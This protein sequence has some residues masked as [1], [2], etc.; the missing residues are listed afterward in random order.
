MPRAVQLL[1][2]LLG[3]VLRACEHDRGNKAVLRE[4]ACQRFELACAVQR[5]Q[6]VLDGGEWLGVVQLDDV[7]VA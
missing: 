1:G 4:D 7:R 3:P 5:E 6:S 2:Q